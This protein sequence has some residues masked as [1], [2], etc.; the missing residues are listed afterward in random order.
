MRG[1]T[2]QRARPSPPT[3]AAVLTLLAAL[4]VLPLALAPRAESFIYWTTDNGE[5]SAPTSTGRG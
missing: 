5:I 3:L 2:R 1:A 4:V